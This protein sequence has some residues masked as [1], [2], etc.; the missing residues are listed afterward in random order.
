MDNEQQPQNDVRTGV[1]FV[2]TATDESNVTR[3]IM[4]QR[5]EHSYQYQ[6]HWCLPGGGQKPEDMNDLR[7]TATREALD[8]TGIQIPADVWKELCDRPA[9]NPGKV[10]IAA[11]P[12]GTQITKGEGAAM[13]W[14]TL[15][16]FKQL[17]REG[18]IGYEHEVWLLPELEQYI[19][20]N[21]E[22]LSEFKNK[23]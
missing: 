11:V 20:A 10:F 9:H 16:E 4:Q 5:D 19:E 15:A 18:V 7:N 12:S 13:E 6:L 21:T 1:N 17:M 2:I 8:E 23:Y 3:F 14:K 22:H